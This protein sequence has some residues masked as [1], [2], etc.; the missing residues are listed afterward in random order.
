MLLRVLAGNQSCYVLL[1]VLGGDESYHVLLHVLGW[2]EGHL[3]LHEHD[4][5]RR[6]PGRHSRH[7]NPPGGSWPGQGTVFLISNQ[8]CP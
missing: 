7:L 4:R 2:D 1:H 6:H 5:H 3:V 8:L